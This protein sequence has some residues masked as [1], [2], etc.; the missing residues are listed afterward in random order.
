MSTLI[1]FLP[2]PETNTAHTG[3]ATGTGVAGDY[4]YALT[5]DGHSLRDQGQVPAALLP[6]PGRSGGEVVALIPAQALSWHQVTLPK[7]VQANTPRLRAVLEGLLEERLLDDPTTLHLA[8]ASPLRANAPVWVAACNRAWLQA[9]VQALE[10]AGRPVARIVPEAT[11]M[12]PGDTSASLLHAIGS[13]D[14]GHWLATGWGAE[15]GV[16]L[17]P[18]SGAALA[19]LAIDADAHLP[20]E[21]WAEPA[22]AAQAEALLGRPVTLQTPAQRWL[23]AARSPCDLAQF[24]LASSGRSRALKKIAARSASLLWAPQ[25]RAARWGVA[26]LLAFNLLGLNAW[27]WHEE[28]ALR[29]KQAALNNMLLKNFPHV[30]TVVVAP[31]QMEREVAL[32]RQASGGISG[33]DLESMLAALSRLAP[34]DR[35]LT[36]IEFAAGEAA[37]KGLNLSA[38]ENRDIALRLQA[39]GYN[40]RSDGEQLRLQRLQPQQQQPQPQRAA[41]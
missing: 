26:A 38:E 12:A 4:R 28:N 9:A 10:S 7:G 31:L 6:Q 21:V 24:E 29:S 17:L 11:P 20:P 30:Q 27:A 8:L 3:S 22:V 18:L 2:P 41:P 39:L 40:A 32:L 34:P 16:S 1:V 5:L 33:G 35:H 23:A 15:R 36:A 25:W 13:A 14:A 37:F 19:L